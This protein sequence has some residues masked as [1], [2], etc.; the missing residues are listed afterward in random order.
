MTTPGMRCTFF[1]LGRL[2]HAYA[3]LDHFIGLQLNWLGEY[4]GQ[5]VAK[6]LRKNVA[7][8][9]RLKCLRQLAIETWGHSDPKVVDEFK[10]WFKE[11]ER[12]QGQRN[13][14][15]HGR[16]GYMRINTDEIEFVE[17]SWESDP[18]KMKP[19]VKVALEDFRRLVGEVERLTHGF[20]SLQKKF[21]S[22]VR[23]KKEW[24]DANPVGFKA[25]A[26]Y[27]AMLSN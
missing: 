26:A 18:A 10:A 5:P 17:L 4:R 20:V 9:R 8:A 14:Y 23:Y 24:E 22:R 11:V 3:R 6:L 15:A 19:A 2:I 16:W 1:L 12:V 13:K 27:Q 7:F 25:W 21:E